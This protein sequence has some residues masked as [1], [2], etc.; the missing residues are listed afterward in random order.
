M[1]KEIKQ[2]I[3]LEGE[4]EYNQAIKEAQRNL[5]TLKSELKAESAELG[6]NATE[7]QKNEAKTKSLQKQIKEQEK[8]V[9][10]LK[11][12]LE[13]AREK[14]GD[15][16][17]EISR[18]E[19]RLNNARTTLAGM[20]NDLE[21][22]GQSLR[23]MGADAAATTVATASV[24][25]ALESIAGAGDSVAGAIESIF[26]GMIDAV[27]GAVEQLWD[28]I[29]QTAAKANRWTDIAGYWNTDAQTVQQYA[30]A[31]AAS[32]NSFDSLNSAVT[33]IVLGGKGKEIT[34]ML[35]ISDVNYTDQWEYA[36]RVMDALYEKR[37][38]GENMDSV[39]E[40]IF[41]AKKATDV[42]DLLNDWGT[43]VELLPQFNGNETGFG[44]NDEELGT[45]NDLWVKINE[46][47]QKWDA[48]KDK[49]A[50]GFGGVS[51]DLLV[52]V[53]GTLDGIA[54]YLN[55]TDDGEKQA[56]LDKIRTNMEEFF[57]KLGEVI[58]E[59]VKVMG[60][61]AQS[62]SESD[63]PTTSLIGDIL[64]K[65]T[66]GLQWIVEHEGEVEGA[67]KALFGAWL[68]AKLAA[69]GGKL[70]AIITQI[71]AVQA[72]KGMSAAA[73][74]SAAGTAAGTSWG[75]AFGSAV[76]KAV[77]WLAGVLTLFE[78]AITAQGN[79]DILDEN[80]ELRPEAQA[81]GFSVDENGEIRR[82]EYQTEFTIPGAEGTVKET[83]AAVAEEI[84]ED[85]DLDEYT[86]EDRKNA[87][88][89][90]W[91]A[92]RNA[93]NGEDSWDEESRAYAWMEQ[94]LGENTGDA[95]EAILRHLDEVEKQNELEDIPDSWWMDPSKWNGGGDGI[96]GSDIAGFRG[97][98]AQL[99][100]AAQKGVSA[101]VSGLRVSIDGQAAGRIL[102]PYV[103]EY[104]ARDMV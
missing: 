43:I 64:L 25:Q 35:G 93:S 4:K 30:R 101:G 18:W 14:Y 16:A 6:R 66:E 62:L 32:A 27:S 58:R 5:R 21:G 67:L 29:S 20:R 80:G 100:L 57:R 59:C 98:P 71:Q 82:P 75:A 85:L 97:L 92:W 77:P 38:K 74:A 55:A 24:G 10:T 11:A 103:S 31:V 78:N 104:I 96:T 61:V 19:V 28:M 7:Q 88:Q 81:L 95:V 12:A 68:L 37:R 26:S 48:L 89:D 51:M 52:N 1:P 56:A 15:N 41:G 3:V 99:Q 2:R 13:E 44:M 84:V 76:L 102:A 8:I 33:K 65:V 72:F 46:I 49:F 9:Q 42:M 79:D 22:T 86:D 39:L 94:V 69:V 47:D 34:E 73:S 50:A 83:A 90:W 60:E 91:D 45:M 53:E 63:D 17:E 23:Q 40:Q 54:D 87:V 36:M 70:A